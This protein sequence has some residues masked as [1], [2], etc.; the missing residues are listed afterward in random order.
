MSHKAIRCSLLMYDDEQQKCS[1]KE[2]VEA[3]NEFDKT[4]MDG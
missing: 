2:F 3:E 4:W 1:F